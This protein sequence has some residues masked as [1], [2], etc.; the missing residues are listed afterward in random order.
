MDIHALK[1]LVT[2]AEVNDLVKQNIPDAGSIDKLQVRLTPE[3]VIVQG[4]YPTMMMRLAFEATWQLSVAGPEVV[5]KLSGVRVAG[6][7]AG[8]LKGALMKMIRDA[9]QG[10][11]GMRVQ[12]DTVRVQVEEAARSQ[13][14][15]VRV[16]FTEVRCSIGALVLEAGGL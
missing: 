3:G 7:P 11:A 9:I 13:G 6:L 4:E 2:E 1:L 15:P 14:V 8:L 10:Q 5:A 16:R 12:D